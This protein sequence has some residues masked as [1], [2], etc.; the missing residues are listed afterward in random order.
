VIGPSFLPPSSNGS[1]SP[2]LG[3]GISIGEPSDSDV[4]T[5]DPYVCDAIKEQNTPPDLDGFDPTTFGVLVD[6]QYS[7]EA[8]IVVSYLDSMNIP[9]ALWIAGCEKD[10]MEFISNESKRRTLQDQDATGTVQYSQVEPW[11]VD[12]RYPRIAFRLISLPSCLS[13]PILGPLL[14]PQVLAY[15]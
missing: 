8:S 5:P 6:V 4:P 13:S 10:A 3:P 15:P 1:F 12:G 9:V 7:T 11:G 2:T 14:L